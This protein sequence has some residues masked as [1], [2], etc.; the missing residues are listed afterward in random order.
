MKRALL[1]LCLLS[2]VLSASSQELSDSTFWDAEMEDSISGMT[3]KPIK[4]PKK[5]LDSIIT[6]LI[7]D[8][9]HKPTVDHR[10]RVENRTFPFPKHPTYPVVSSCTFLAGAGIKLKPSG[11]L[12]S[13]SFEGPVKLSSRDSSGIMFTLGLFSTHL[14]ILSHVHHFTFSDSL[15]KKRYSRN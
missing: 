11:N 15:S 5:L 9:E 1:L 13:F 14:P 8:W 6:Q 2:W 10:Y 3:I 4:K 12:E 7:R